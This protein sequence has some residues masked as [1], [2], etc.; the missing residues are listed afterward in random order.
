LIEKTAIA[1]AA[2]WYSNNWASVN[3]SNECGVTRN[4]YAL[5]DR[6]DGNYS[7]SSADSSIGNVTHFWSTTLSGVKAYNFRIDAS[8]IE[9]Y[10]DTN[11]R[12]CGF[13]VRLF[14]DN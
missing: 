9:V 8:D 11:A 2:T 3:F 10:E 4:F 13:P 5:G 1:D 6:L 7:G 12:G 14:K